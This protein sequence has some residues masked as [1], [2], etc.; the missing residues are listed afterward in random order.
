MKAEFRIYENTHTP[1]LYKYMKPDDRIIR[2]AKSAVKMILDLEFEQYD[3]TSRQRHLTFARECFSSLVR[4]NTNFSL[5]Y[6]GALYKKKYDHST[7]IAQC[8]NI[9]NLEFMGRR[10]DRFSDWE[11]IKENFNLMTK[12]N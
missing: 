2:A 10:D 11:Q 5:R 6:I 7:I 4:S 8:G 12:F 1:L 9:E 3:T